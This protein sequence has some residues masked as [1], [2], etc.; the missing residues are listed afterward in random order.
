MIWKFEKWHEKSDTG[1][2]GA[3]LIYHESMRTF[4]KIPFVF[5][6]AIRIFG[7]GFHLVKEVLPPNR[8]EIMREFMQEEDLH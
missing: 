1:I 6:F 8:T 5:E 2:L 7:H 4:Q 3:L